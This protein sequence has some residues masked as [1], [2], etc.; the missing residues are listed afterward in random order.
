[1]AMQLKGKL[2][3]KNVGIETKPQVKTESLSMDGA[4]NYKSQ[5]SFLH[6]VHSVRREGRLKA[7]QY[8]PQ[9]TRQCSVRH[10]TQ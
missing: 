4:A 1:M 5:Y 10:T 3:V 9:R 2:S 8:F 6:V 7:V